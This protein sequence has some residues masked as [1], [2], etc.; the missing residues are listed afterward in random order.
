MAGLKK[1][2]FRA[3]STEVET[4]RL[5]RPWG[6]RR[7]SKGNGSLDFPDRGGDGATNNHFIATVVEAARLSRSEW[8]R[9]DFPDQGGYGAFF[10][11]EAETARL[12]NNS[13]RPWWMRRDFSN[14]SRVSPDHGAYGATFQ[15]KAETARFSRPR[16]RT[17]T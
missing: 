2:F 9:R 8:R 5:S 3:F 15:N 10:Q 17:F 7:D 13:L 14:Q 6:I 1:K 11:T 4:A 16:R 12:R